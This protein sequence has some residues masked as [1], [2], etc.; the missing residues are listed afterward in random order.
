MFQ[1][2]YKSKQI[3]LT[4]IGDHVERNEFSSKRYIELIK[5]KLLYP[6]NLIIKGPYYSEK[7]G[8]NI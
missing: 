1:H 6:E 4:L 3:I 5:S 7:N 2:K 8:K